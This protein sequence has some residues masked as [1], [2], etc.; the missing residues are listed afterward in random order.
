MGKLFI[1]KCTN[2][3]LITVLRIHNCA[4]LKSQQPKNHYSKR[5]LWLTIPNNIE[6]IEWGKKAQRCSVLPEGDT[7]CPSILADEIFDSSFQPVSCVMVHKRLFHLSP[8]AVGW[9]R[10]PPKYVNIIDCFVNFRR[11]DQKVLI[12]SITFQWNYTRCFRKVGES[13][14]VYQQYAN[15]R[16]LICKTAGSVNGQIAFYRWPFASDQ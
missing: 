3:T 11:G 14:M 16:H 9:M 2:F 5:T 4:G 10:S 1:L 6:V 8:V 13:N 15:K 12:C 7:L